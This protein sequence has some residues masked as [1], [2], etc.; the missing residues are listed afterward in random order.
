VVYNIEMQS[1]TNEGLKT[2]LVTGA[3]RGIGKAIAEKFLTEG[4]TVYGTYFSS[5]EPMQEIQSK[6]GADK[7]VICGPYDFRNLVDTKKLITDLLGVELNAMVINAGI[8]IENDDFLNFDLDVFNQTMNCNFYTPLI[9]GIQLQNNIL[10]NGS[11]TIISSTDAYRGAYGSMSYSISKSALLSLTK[12]LCVNYGH[13]NIR[14]NSISP[15]AIDTDMNTPEQLLESPNITPINRVGQPAEIANTAFFLAS[16]SSSFINGENITVDGGYANVDVLLKKETG[17][18]REFRGYDY[19]LDKYKSMKEG[20]G[21][22]HIIPS[23]YFTWDDSPEEQ[24]VQKENA[25]AEKRGAKIDRIVIVSA[26]NEDKIKKSNL[27]KLYLANVQPQ[28]HLY[29]IKETDLIKHNPNDYQ[30]VGS[31]FGVLN[32][33]EALVDSY[34]TVDSI[35]YFIE[36]ESF[37][38]QLTVAFSNILENIQNGKISTLPW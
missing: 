5:I 38:N 11:I 19:V 21:L 37:I 29:L 1:I 9:L 7:F 10:N 8:F 17:R 25:L 24:E 36:G 16:A 23:D 14:V 33:K 6:F 32:G 4:Y 27:I 30:R 12:C 15:G 35:G 2:V 3:S 28:G 31:G 13:R 20:D 22:I 18:I 26:E 34:S